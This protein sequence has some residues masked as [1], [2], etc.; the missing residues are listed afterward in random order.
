MLLDYSIL[1]VVL[2]GI[3]VSLFY[4]LLTGISPVSSSFKSRRKIIQTV[5]PDQEG[6]IYELGAGWGA[7]AFPLAKRCPGATVIAYELSPVPWLFLKMRA[8]L[9][10]PR[11][12]RI[13]RRNFI[14]EDLSKASLVVCY[15]YP[16]A[17]TVLSSK[18]VMELK[19]STT[20]ISNT[21]PIPAWTPCFIQNLEDV[22][23]PQI[24][25]YKM[26]N[27][28]TRVCTSLLTSLQA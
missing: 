20:V 5:N 7:L 1:A 23:C 12:L 11:N 26:E 3:F 18:L 27:A 16:G 15:L 28:L 21:F 22:M 10:G 8:L 14:K 25:H 24:F 13:V 2:T 19:S 9:F 4:S 17:M 6:F